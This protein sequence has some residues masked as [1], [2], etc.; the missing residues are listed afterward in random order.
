M[1]LVEEIY[2]QQGEIKKLSVFA[3]RFCGLKHVG[4]RF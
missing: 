2:T 4:R 3:R 1:A